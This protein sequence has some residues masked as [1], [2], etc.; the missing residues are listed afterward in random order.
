[1]RVLVADDDLG[2][3]LVAKAAVEALGHDCVTAQDGSEAWRLVLELEPDVLVTDR[4]MPGL[5]GV[6]LCRRI[7]AAHT[8]HYTYIVLLTALADPQDVL[9]GMRA[10]ADD[11]VTKP[12]NPLDLEARLV[13]AQRITALHTELARTRAELTRQAATDPLTGLRNRLMLTDDLQQLHD[14][15]ARYDR[16]YALAICDIDF[17]KAYNDTHGHPQGDVALR[18]VAA[19]MAGT[20]RGVDRV[21]RYGG[22]EFLVLLP[23]QALAQAAS[24]VERVRRAVADLAIPHNGGRPGGVVTLSVGVAAST[25]E[26]RLTSHQILT[27]ADQAL[28]AAKATGRNRVCAGSPAGQTA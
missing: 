4:A 25:P 5:D 9:A 2:S 23:E 11:Y 14:V 16:G 7:R 6:T 18:A 15:S 28:Y 22:E 1:M 10:G 17:F 8:D 13:A 21:Y 24:A 12:L 19:A 27:E 26:H 3:R 20:L